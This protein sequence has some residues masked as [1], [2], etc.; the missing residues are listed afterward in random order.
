MIFL[1]HTNL[2]TMIVIKFISSLQKGVYRYE[3]MNDW[4]NFYKTSSPE[5]YFYSHLNM[6][7]I[8]DAEKEKELY[9]TL[10]IDIQKLIRNTW[11][12]MMKIKNRHIFNIEM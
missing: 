8:T 4:E 10:K 5:K 7:D 2:L 11:N 9:V 12:F 3:D 6:E 1:K